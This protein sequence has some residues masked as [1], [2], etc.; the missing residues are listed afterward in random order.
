MAPVWTASGRGTLAGM[1]A[2]LA[3][4]L[5]GL[6]TG[7]IP[8]GTVVAAGALAGGYAVGCIPVAWLLVRRAE[9]QRLHHGVERVEGSGFPGAAALR[10]R[11]DRN[12]PGTLDTLAAGGYRVA[13][14]TVA[15]ELVKGAVVGFGARAYDDSSWF[16]AFAIA[17]CVVG[18]AFPLG[19]R[20]G[21]RGVAPLISGV[22]AGL[23]GAWTAGVIIAIPAVVILAVGG[24]AYDGVLAVC[25]PLAFVVGTHDPVTLVPAAIVV[26]ALVTRGRIRRQA[27]PGRGRRAARPPRPSGRRR[28]R[29]AA[30]SR[31]GA[32]ALTSAP[33]APSA[34][35]R[36]RPGTM[37]R[38]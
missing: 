36:E 33:A 12:R 32:A 20:R 29:G 26:V 19:L 21:R 18:D 23:P 37:H 11:Y 31:P 2:L 7:P 22:W 14:V 28:R 27:A 38:R 13:L 30:P 5:L 4:A 24:A 6:S 10:R 34:G 8:Q 16:A 35:R 9:R 1:H 25:V 15:L 17:G 3:A